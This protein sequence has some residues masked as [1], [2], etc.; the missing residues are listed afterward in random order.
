MFCAE[1]YQP[2]IMED[3]YLQ[4]KPMMA[5]DSVEDARKE[6]LGKVDLPDPTKREPERVYTDM[7]VFSRLSLTLVNHFKPIYVTVHLE[8]VLFK[9]VL[10]NGG[11][12]INV[13][14]Y[15]QMKRVY[16]SDEDLIPTNLIVSSFSRAITRTH[17]ILPL[18]VDLGSKQI[19]LAF[20]VVD[21]TSTYGALLGRDWI[22]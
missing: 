9:K 3:D 20:F 8:G 13:L 18:E 4:T 21:S 17:E 7:M 14:P 15:K 22:Q 10:I 5:H 6:E 12:A 2:A 19:M 16:R 1:Y 11:A